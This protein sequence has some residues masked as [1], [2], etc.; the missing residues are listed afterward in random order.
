MNANTGPMTK[1]PSDAPALP[2]NLT[3]WRRIVLDD[4]RP[5]PLE[6]A[7]G[8]AHTSAVYATRCTLEL[9][10][11]YQLVAP[12]GKGKSTLLHILFGLRSDYQGHVRFEDADIR[13]L[14]PGAW[15]AIR[16]HALGMVFQDLRLLPELTGRENIALKWA[17]AQDLPF[18]EVERWAARLGVAQ[19]LDQPAHTLSYGQQQRVAI[20]R[21]LSGKFRF[22][23]LDEPF[24]HLD[25]ETAETARNLIEERCTHL[26]AGL[27]VTSL[28]PESEFENALIVNI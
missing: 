8:S 12:S 20:L 14:P 1:N 10:Q 13:S 16:A 2:T 21:A 17:I 28:R 18:A 15:A 25:P 26:D 11:R 5:A 7:L 22:L 19:V 23:L 27:M 24:S 9:A 4:L 3:G 6:Q